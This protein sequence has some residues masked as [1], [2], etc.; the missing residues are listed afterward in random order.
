MQP[1]FYVADIFFNFFKVAWTTHS[2]QESSTLINYEKKIRDKDG[3]KRTKH[4]IERV[5]VERQ[6][7][8]EI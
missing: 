1:I 7:E 2:P 4:K 6:R 8:M 3:Q 5:K